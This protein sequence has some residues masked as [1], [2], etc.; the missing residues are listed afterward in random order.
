MKMIE[1]CRYVPEGYE[2]VAQDAGLGIE[3]FANKATNCARGFSGRRNKP[4]FSYRF[5]SAEKMQ[6]Y[7]EEYVVDIIGTA[8]RKEIRKNERL[9]A[10]RNA[11]VNVG[12]I[13]RASWGYDQTNIDYYQVVAVSGQNI[14]VRAIAQQSQETLAMQGVCVPIPNSFI[15]EVMKK[16]IQADGDSL[17]FRVN[18]F[19][20]AY[21]EKPVAVVAGVPIFK[22]ASWTAYA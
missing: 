20:N 12:D 9:E 3:V 14:Q 16:R 6:A 1:K 7:I 11:K 18:S 17:S 22:E 21:L 2:L 19:S 15:G 13:F 10:A 4:D 5:G 8:K